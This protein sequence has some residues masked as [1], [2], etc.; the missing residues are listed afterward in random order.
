MRA[1][2][3]SK[4][5]RTA[6]LAAATLATGLFAV[7]QSARADDPKAP[8]KE[9]A[10][11]SQARMKWWNQA[12]FGMFIHWGLYAVPADATDLK[13]NKSIA[14]W[15]L[16]NKQMQVKDYEK[17]AAQ[18][19]PVKFDAKAWVKVA[20]DAGMKYI[21]ITSKHHDGFC[22]FDSKLTDYNI[23]AAT[24]FKRDPLKELAAACREAGVTLCFYHSIMDWHHPDYLPRR[25]WEKTTRPA[26][27][28]DLNKYIDYM[29]GQLRELL[30]NYGPVG[31][32]WFDGGWEHDAKATRSA[33]VV[34]MMRSLQPNLIINNR[35]QRPEDFDTP[36]QTI[37]AAALADG[38]PWETCM[39][40]NDTW[41][42]ARNDHNWKSAEDLIHKLCDIAHKGGNFLLNVG[43][44]ELGEIPPASVERLET[45]GAWM[46]SNGEAIYGTTKSPFRKLTFNGRC[47]SKGSTLYLHVFDWPKDE[48][49]LRGVHS[50]LLRVRALD[51]GVPLGFEEKDG[52]IT[53][54]RPDKLDK[55]ATVVALEFD[56]TPVV[57]D[58]AT[59]VRP[60][61]NG[62]ITLSAED[63]T[64]HGGKI[65]LEDKGG[66]PSVGFWTDPQDYLSWLVEVPNPPST[67]AFKQTN[68][69]YRV[70]Y[71][72]A[73]PDDSDGASVELRFPDPAPI[74][75]PT[76]FE[77]T[78]TGG[79]GNFKTK[80]ASQPQVLTLGFLVQRVV[81]L[82]AVSMPK[83]AVMNLRSIK[84]I[85]V[86][87][88]SK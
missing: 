25:P 84:L 71:E 8:P 86:E 49:T 31:V 60:D 56:G 23:V 58:V 73:C 87:D 29:K 40:L 68:H 83:Y 67:A 66:K 78:P 64:L 50:K 12:K 4:R 75:K 33:E 32:I 44:T 55:Y 72:Y 34:A 30:T 52:A 65:Q 19:N 53:I 1:H 17:F 74:P 39:T 10:A 61:K 54:Q 41:G 57:E 14:E 43:P 42:Y 69:A 22:M 16:S 48:L 27:D 70:E 18:F 37:P 28:A 59:I 77:V 51:G 76:V 81:K 80:A 36:E 15:Y 20:K 21:V 82:R 7:A 24:P 11:Q 45:V 35:I 26:G 13:G 62:V 47:T 79:W 9:S 46:K 3:V 6:I 88:R 85:P 63:A 38:R 2:D 5:L